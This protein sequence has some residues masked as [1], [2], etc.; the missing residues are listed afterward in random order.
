[1]RKTGNVKVT[2]RRGVPIPK[3]HEPFRKPYGPG[4]GH[5]WQLLSTN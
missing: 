3:R 5:G 4:G 2:I 1:M